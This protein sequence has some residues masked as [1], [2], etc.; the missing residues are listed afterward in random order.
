MHVQ[1]V[2]PM[3]AAQSA[4]QTG[5]EI[6]RAAVARGWRVIPLEHGGKRP[7]PGRRWGGQRELPTDAQLVEWFGA[8]ERNVGIL[9]G[10]SG[11]VILDEDTK[12]AL[13]QAAAD[14]GARMPE[15]YTVETPKGRHYYFA[16]PTNR[17]GNSRGALKPYGI[18]VRGGHGDGGY[19]VAAGCLHPSG[20]R[21]RVT[22]DREPAPL[23]PWIAAALEEEPANAEVVELPVLHNTP[24]PGSRLENADRGER[25]F[26]ED[27]ARRYIAA[28]CLAPLLAAQE[29]D[30][31]EQLNRS[32]VVLG[33]FVPEFM[34]DDLERAVEFLIPHAL[35]IGLD[36]AEIRPTAL[37]GLRRGAAEPYTKVSVLD[38]APADPDGAPEGGQEAL[39]SLVARQWA[40]EQFARQNGAQSPEPGSTSLADLLAEELEG[41]DWRIS[42]L[43][44]AGGKVLLAAPRKTGK[45]TLIGNLVRSL[46]DGDPFLSTEQFA[47]EVS[48]RTVVI[49]DFE[50]TRRQL[51][52]WMR[53][54]GIQNTASVHVELLRGKR[55]DPTDPR[56]RARWAAYL[57][58]LNA[59][60]L[61]IDPAG[62][63]VASLDQDENE[64]GAVRRFLHSLDALVAESGADELFVAHHT[65]WGGERSRG[66]SAWED[67]PDAIWR[68]AGEVP[69]TFFGA[70]GRD[71]DQA[72]RELVFDPAS[73]RYS[74]GDSTRA[75]AKVSR[76]VELVGRIVAAQPMIGKNQ[77][78]EALRAKG[79]ASTQ[80]Q[81]EAVDA[82]IGE[83]VHTHRGLK[84]AVLHGSTGQCF[85]GCPGA[86]DTSNT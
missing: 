43:W 37:S 3:S 18:D 17:Y 85:P 19:V 69:E 74:L 16:D 4:T 63:V 80:R 59:G 66:A 21:Y 35:T 51:Q 7:V 12:T 56:E 44:P 32:A 26:T 29:G 33:H 53:D 5:L 65:G 22:D 48:G 68:L 78:R 9:A 23:L 25:T 36:R 14:R 40:A 49:L 41:E 34:G 8:E 73:R 45:T 24:A 72:A 46:V 13:A 62:P 76:D 30:R 82:A 27:Q 54:Q 58:D 64:N 84:N 52:R 77:L 10:P 50:M 47:T 6:A 31:N 15:T 60:V 67:W 55:W 71:V 57:K 70:L 86:T 81:T 28:E 11:L 75:Q 1:P 83:T 42:G 39:R 79:M 2:E 61:I 20:A 38:P